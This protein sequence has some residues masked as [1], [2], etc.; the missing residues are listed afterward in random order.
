MTLTLHYLLAVVTCKRRTRRRTRWRITLRTLQLLT[1]GCVQPIARHVVE[2]V[3]SLVTTAKSSCKRLLPTLCRIIIIII[4]IISMAICRSGRRPALSHGS[5]EA[6]LV[7]LALIIYPDHLLQVYGLLL[8]SR[9]CTIVIVREN[10]LSSTL[11]VLL[12][13]MW[14]CRG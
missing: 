12:L 5:S 10:L 9:W 11:V 2:W 13:V 8:E 14:T 6:S 7:L 3:T 4:I 1:E